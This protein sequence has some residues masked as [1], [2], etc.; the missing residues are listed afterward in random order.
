MADT[1]APMWAS[2]YVTERR[3]AWLDGREFL[4]W[5]WEQDY[6]GMPVVIVDDAGTPVSVA[7]I[8]FTDY[9]PARDCS[10]C[11]ARHGH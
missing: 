11:G 2:T 9:D 10:H 6:D 4:P 3:E 8:A 7:D 1:R 5:V